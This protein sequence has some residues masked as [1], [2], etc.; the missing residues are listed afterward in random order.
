[1]SLFTQKQLKPCAAKWLGTLRSKHV[2]KMTYACHA[3]AFESNVVHYEPEGFEQLAARFCAK[4]V[5]SLLMDVGETFH[6][7]MSS[8]WALKGSVHASV[9]SIVR[10]V[11][12]SSSVY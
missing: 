11:V 5:S 3:G 4:R 12:L 8:D 9:H 10:C 1:M 7:Q 2:P 6:G